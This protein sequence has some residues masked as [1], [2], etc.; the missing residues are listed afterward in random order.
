MSQF[1]INS[2]PEPTANVVQASQGSTPMGASACSGLIRLLHTYRM[3]A[4]V[5]STGFNLRCPSSSLSH[6]G[7]PC[8]PKSPSTLSPLTLT[9]L[10]A[11]LPTLWNFFFPSH[12]NWNDFIHTGQIKSFSVS[13]I[14]LNGFHCPQKM[15]EFPI[16]ME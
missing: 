15:L 3:K 14:P 4:E 9:A 8:L 1:Q 12:C 10:S 16:V 7:P 2:G 11:K 6:A 13:Q 5:N